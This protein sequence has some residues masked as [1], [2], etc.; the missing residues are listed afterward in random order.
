M[1]IAMRFTQRAFFLSL[2]GLCAASLLTA[3]HHKDVVLTQEAQADLTP[4]A[5]LENLME[6][7]ARY[8]AGE[9]TNQKH[10]GRQI[11][12]TASGQFPQAIILSCVDS[13][14]PVEQVFDQRV[15]DIF[16]ARVAGNVENVD[17]LGSMEFATAAAGARLVMVL[18]HEACGAVKG[19]CDHVQLGNLTA[20]LEKITPAVVA[21]QDEYPPEE[22]TSKNAEFVA[23]VIEK[24]VHLT[25][26]DIRR[27]S[28]ILAGLE[29]DGTIEIVG[30]HYALDT[31]EVTL[32]R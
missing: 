24:N 5:V 7:N 9:L 16:V 30:A 23:A 1:L 8:V 22:R 31:G 10:L 6:G 28:P 18:G 32:L 14:V 13:R 20:L 11:E 25:V 3:K 15:G 4:E 26:D 19:A 12:A 17:I 2:L 27:N 29:A 21:V